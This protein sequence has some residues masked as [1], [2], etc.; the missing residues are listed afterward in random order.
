MTVCPSCRAEN[1]DA[2]KFCIACGTRL[3]A[4]VVPPAAEVVPVEEAAAEPEPEPV[5]AVEPPVAEAPPVEEAAAEPVPEEAIDEE[6][7]AAEAPAVEEAA[8]EPVSEEAIDEEPSAAEAPPVEE[9]VVEPVP[10]EVAGGEPPIDELE[11]VILLG[12]LPP[13]TVLEGR[14]EIVGVVARQADQATYR[15]YDRRRCWACGAE[16]PS[17]EEGAGA[18]EPPFC[19]GC[20]AEL[21]RPATSLLHEWLAPPEGVGAEDVFEHR[22]RFFTVV[23]EE[24]SG[25]EGPFPAGVRLVAG[26]RSLK[27]PDRAINQDSLL[28]LTL[29]PI[30]EGKPAPALGL[31]AVADGIGGHEGGEVAS[32][33]AVQVLAQEIASSM[34]LAELGGDAGLDETLTEIVSEAVLDANAQVYAVARGCGNDMGSTLT[35]VLVR[36]DLA[37][38]ANVGDSRTY[39]WH[40]GALHQLTTDHSVVERLVATGAITREEAASHAQRGVLYRSLGDR[41]TVEVDVLS[42]RLEPGDRLILCCDGVWESLED[43]GLEEV[44]LLE[45]DPQR[46]CDE[47]SRRA[48]EAGSSD[49][50]SVTVV[51]V[52]EM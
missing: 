31:Y 30:Y 46:I 19:P 12:S 38:V 40:D 17:G 50:V 25:E 5:A 24:S 41:A 1:R 39:H 49:N 15:A 20:G 6:P 10:E 43:E 48:L 28:V 4:A 3:V 51:S 11:T 16:V 52:L 26:M 42:L 33:I 36:D 22:G 27:G 18:Q 7:P 37:I 8:G 35:T 9:T 45:V 21:T 23:E 29:T 13:G 14:Y 2:A 32:R 44:M 47:L 34:L